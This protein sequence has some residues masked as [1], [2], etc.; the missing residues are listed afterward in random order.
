MRSG[1]GRSLRATRKPGSRTLNSR[2]SRTDASRKR[3]KARVMGGTT[4]TATL[5]LGN[6]M[7]HSIMAATM[8]A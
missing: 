2:R 8:A 5:I 3:Q 7:P 6:D 1:A 4:A